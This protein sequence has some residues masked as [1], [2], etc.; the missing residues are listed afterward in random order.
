MGWDGM[1]WD[2]CYKILISRSP[3]HTLLKHPSLDIVF[4][5][6]LLVHSSKRRSIH[7]IECS[8]EYAL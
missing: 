8:R 5:L 6:N 7:D 4:N 1:G 3:S 2:T